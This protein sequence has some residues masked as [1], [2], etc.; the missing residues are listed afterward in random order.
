[1][2]SKNRKSNT[3]KVSSLIIFIYSITVLIQVFT[4]KYE[5][6][7]FMSQLKYIMF[8]ATCGV[9]ILYMNKYK[10]FKVFQY[11]FKSVLWIIISFA[12]IS[13][14]RA[15]YVKSFTN[16]T[17]QELLFLLI[18]ILVSYCILNTLDKR[19]I[20]KVMMFTL[21]VSIMGYL[22]EVNMGVA[23]FI[24]ALLSMSFSDSY[25]ML[26]SSTFAGIS[27][28]TAMY[29][30]YYRSNKLGCILSIIFV[31]LTFK[32]LA[33][34]FVIFLI[35]VPKIFNCNKKVNYTL[36][37]YIKIGIILITFCYFTI[38]IPENVDKINNMFNIDLYKLTM[39]RTYRF[40]LIYNRANFIN[41][42]L[43]STYSYMMSLY[44][45]SLEMDMIKLL[46][47]VT[48]I[49][50][51]IFVNNMFNTAKKNWY[52][53][54]LMLFQFLNL[55]TSHSLTSVFSWVIFY[56]TIGCVLYKNDLNDNKKS[57]K[58]VY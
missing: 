44:K 22:V 8:L 41:T 37:N 19:K 55:I 45:V 39:S 52:C 3:I 5:N 56:I 57:K 35:F 51:I 17:I 48:P 54:I 4:A 2:I 21:I 27:I 6:S 50:V 10:K 12:I 47:E 25:S 58:I 46:I 15:L 23:E 1:M 40:K 30:L 20:D 34:V 31:I 26:E 43:G 36:M 18:P 28:S 16:R 11:E 53:M 14:I 7:G 38:M 24:Q 32:R 49:G 29:F 9:C 42:G 33:I 13:I